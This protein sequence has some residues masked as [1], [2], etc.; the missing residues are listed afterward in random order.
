M[1]KMSSE[2]FSFAESTTGE[3][4][5]KY[6]E[7]V[8]VIDRRRRKRALLARYEISAK[9]ILSSNMRSILGQKLQ[10]Y[11]ASNASIS[12]E[13]LLIPLFADSTWLIEILNTASPDDEKVKLA[14]EH[15]ISRIDNEWSSQKPSLTLLGQL[16][17]AI[18]NELSQ[19]KKLRQ[20][21]YYRNR[22]VSAI[23][24]FL[25]ATGSK[26]GIFK[27]RITSADSVREWLVLIQNEFLMYDFGERASRNS[28]LT[29]FET[30][31]YEAWP[32][33][34]SSA[35]VDEDK[36]FARRIQSTLS[37]RER[38]PDQEKDLDIA[39]SQLS[40]LYEKAIPETRSRIDLI[41]SHGGVEFKAVKGQ[42]LLGHY[43]P[44]SPSLEKLQ[45]LSAKILAASFDEDELPDITTQI[46]EKPV[47]HLVITCPGK[48]SLETVK[49]FERF[50]GRT[51]SE[52]A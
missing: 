35:K 41:L 15:F 20:F 42:G 13:D 24:K 1:S 26:N 48:P 7:N 23:F 47:L 22:S 52:E 11:L 5:L 32:D 2:R 16:E 27:Q 17:V 50:V 21:Y 3:D 8:F 45:N 36:T 49:V 37:N 44:N 34:P 19:L 12:A 43:I 10:P 28:Y 51:L 40:S 18:Q 30:F 46:V 14:L 38:T 33:I 4:L 6:L 25:W 39:Y 9:D 31:I 29:E